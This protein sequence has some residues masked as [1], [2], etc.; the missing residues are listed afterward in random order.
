MKLKEFTVREFRSIWDSGPIALDEQTTCLV[1]KNE[2]G[3]TALLTALYRTDPIA[4]SASFDETYDYPK[5]EVED[6][7]F[8]VENGDREEAVVVECLYELEDDDSEAV[9]EIF[10]PQGSQS[11]QPRLDQATDFFFGVRLRLELPDLHEVF[12]LIR[13]H[14]VHQSAG[15]QDR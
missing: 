6:Y 13:R 10:G 14:R 1:G 11:R 12:Q 5:R 3:K 9:S 2:A 8:E 15:S 7:R 4:A